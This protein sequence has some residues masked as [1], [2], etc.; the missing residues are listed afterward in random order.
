M[1]TPREF[2]Q[3]QEYEFDHFIKQTST[4]VSPDYI[5]IELF[6]Y[7]YCKEVLKQL[8]KESDEQ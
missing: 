2:R 4:G 8:N 6:A 3:R 5:S 7:D 1:E